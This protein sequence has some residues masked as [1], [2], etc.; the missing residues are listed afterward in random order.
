M[1]VQWHPEELSK[2]DQMSANLFYNF[3]SAAAGDWRSQVPAEWG[4]QFYSVCIAPHVDSSGE[5]GQFE[6]SILAPE[7]SDTGHAG[8]NGKV[9]PST[10][11]APESAPALRGNCG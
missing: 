11:A 8:G 3:V 1:G 10:W 4:E 2:T 7:R 9:A 5:P 6:P